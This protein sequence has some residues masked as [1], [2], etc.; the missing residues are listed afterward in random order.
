MN[1]DRT[2][3]NYEVVIL[4][5]GPA[6]CATALALR[7]CGISRILVVESGDYRSPRIGESLPPD[8]RTLLDR[9]GIWEDFLAEKH[10]PCLGSLS[11]WGSDELGYN[12]FLFNPHGNGWHLDRNRFEGFLAGKARE[13]G[14]ELNLNTRFEKSES[15]ADGFRLQLADREGATRLVNARFIV[16]AT[17][18]SA[19]FARQRGAKRRFL[20]RLICVSGFFEL[21]DDAVFSRLTL[22]EAV[23]YGW[24]YAAR[25]PNRRLVV[26]VASDPEII[27]RLALHQSDAWLDRSRTTN[28]LAREL[29]GCLFCANS[30]LIRGASS[31]LL[32]RV[33]GKAWLAIGDAASTYDPISSQ[34]IYKALF[35]S[36][37]AAPIIAAYLD[38][39]IRS[40][41]DYAASIVRGFQGYWHNRDY[42]YQLEKRW[43]TS[44]FWKKRVQVD[45]RELG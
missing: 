31:S 24:W 44:S 1:F 29:T 25:L 4:G 7:Q 3:D 28:H 22:L 5:G 39:D 34:G 30:L 16:D 37:Q 43:I 35:D 33:A 11:A 36:L 42:F 14:A 10:E 21:P 2:D 9:L 26:A 17:G 40:I 23:E 18:V 41:E 13:S 8:T 15:V 6:G 38:G 45:I 27:R 12:D 20:D 19:S 32:D